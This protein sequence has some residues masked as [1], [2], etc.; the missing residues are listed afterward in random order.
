MPHHKIRKRLNRHEPKIVIWA[1]GEPGAPALGALDPE[2]LA[3]IEQH[4]CLLVTRNRA[5]MP[6]HLRDHLAAGRHVPGILTS[7]KEMLAW[8]VAD[9]LQ[10]IWE[11]MRPGEY[12]D[13]IAYLPVR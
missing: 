4:D 10:L 1:V 3:W 13:L 7:P 8:E 6:G 2:L 9:E 5:S 11:V 12:L